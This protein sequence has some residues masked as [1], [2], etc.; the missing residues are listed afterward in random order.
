MGEWKPYPHDWHFQLDFPRE[1]LTKHRHQPVKYA[2]ASHQQA[3]YS[4]KNRLNSQLHVGAK[5]MYQGDQHADAPKQ[6]DHF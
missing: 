2:V 4:L 3:R 5:Q 6:A 1:G